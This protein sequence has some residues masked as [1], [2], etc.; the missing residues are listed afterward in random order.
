MKALVTYCQKTLS[1]PFAV[2]ALAV[3]ASA[4]S[5]GMALIAQYAFGLEPCIL[6]LYQRV[7]F[8]VV[9]VIGLAALAFRKRK[10]AL[11][12][13]ALLSGIAFSAN[14]VIAAYHT[15]V[16][17]HWWKSFL[18]SC[19]APDFLDNPENLLES[20]LK[21]P[22][23][24]CDEIPWADPLLG[25]SMANYNVAFCAGLAVICFASF[26]ISNRGDACDV[27]H[28]PEKT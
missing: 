24:R 10:G 5:L 6:C 15:G 23:V 26:A 14:S 8:A 9:I 22:A 28:H 2:I 20:L 3:A 17:Q 21:A 18:E 1:C 4:F 25:L 16:E 13:G 11:R 27:K 19:S 12:L 7:P